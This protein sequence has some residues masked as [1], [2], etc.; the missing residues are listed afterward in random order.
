M[1]AVM[2]GNRARDS[3]PETRLRSELH[4]AGLRFRLH[5]KIGSGR[6]APRPDVVFPRERVALFLDGCFW[7]SCPAHGTKPGTNSEYWH[8]KLERNRARDARNTQTL[9]A[10]GWLVIRVWEHEDP[11][12][13]ALRVRDDVLRRR[14]STVGSGCEYC[15]P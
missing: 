7:H 12:D 5:R 4:R 9:L 10:A 2:Q 14:A 1:R 6:S 11:H 3:S 13:A 15:R 8:A